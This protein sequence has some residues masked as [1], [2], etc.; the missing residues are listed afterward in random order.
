VIAT[1]TL[2]AALDIT[3]RLPAVELHG[4][5]RVAA[6]SAQ[7]GGKGINVARVLQALGEEVVACCL[8]GGPTGEAVRAG[9]D[10][11]ATIVPIAGETRRTIT[12]VDDRDAT[13]FWE[14]GPWVTRDEWTAVL[15][16]FD[17]LAADAIVLSGS[18]PRGVPDDAYAQLIRRADVPVILDADGAALRLGVAAGPAVVKP[19]RAELERSG[20]DA[21]ALLAAGAG[22][23]V[24][25]LGEQ[26]LV[27]FTGEG[28]FRAPA[29]ERIGGGNPTGAGDAV[30]AALAR[31]LV[32][33]TP[34]PELVREAA[35]L[36]AA[37]V[38]APVAGAFDA[39]V[40]RRLRPPAH[41]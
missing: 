35:A 20:G 29:P 32:A 5:N 15:A 14:P 38:A 13:G 4:V 27:A 21:E 16:A 19:N 39:A 40:Y 7:A 17:G 23:V 2:N 37:A 12:V 30:A 25:T 36:G 3:Y 33:G 34:W 8:L 24:V 18:L 31:G 9:L 1:V 26:G 41:D 11:P 6:V 22:A 28:A 10:S